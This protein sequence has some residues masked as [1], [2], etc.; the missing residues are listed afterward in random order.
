LRKYFSSCEVFGMPKNSNKSEGVYERKG[1]RKLTEQEYK[2]KLAAWY[3]LLP[4]D[5]GLDPESGLV[6]HKAR[7][8]PKTGKLLNP[9]RLRQPDSAFAFVVR[10]YKRD[11][12]THIMFEADLQFR[13]EFMWKP[14][15]RPFKMIGFSL[16]RLED[17]APL[18]R[19]SRNLRYKN[20]RHVYLK[21]YTIV[22]FERATRRAQANV[23]GPIGY[24]RESV[25]HIKDRIVE[26]GANSVLMIHNCPSEDCAPPSISDDLVALCREIFPELEAH[27]IIYPTS[28]D[29]IS[30]KGLRI[31]RVPADMP[32]KPPGPLP[33][34]PQLTI[35]SPLAE[36]SIL[37]AW[38]NA[39]TGH[40]MYSVIS[41]GE[42]ETPQVLQQT[43]LWK[44]YDTY[45]E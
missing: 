22:D 41:V 7:F 8:D 9:M 44:L 14:K 4:E 25:T 15:K 13:P 5:V 26:L 18:T 10:D 36:S 32:K 27:I 38:A 37:A 31:V 33:P 45:V 21:D 2:E 30:V 1:R 16:E 28:F 39:L 29:L 20:L 17:L 24:T 34:E 23:P 42:Q 19:A 35:S 40:K 3:G 6:W 43:A 12:N 11:P